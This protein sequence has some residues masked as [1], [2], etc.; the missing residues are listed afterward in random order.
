[1]A[2]RRMKSITCVLN[3]LYVENGVK[4]IQREYNT[5]FSVVKSPTFSLKFSLYTLYLF[6]LL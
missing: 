3:M 4:I 2:I 5:N 1:M 6:P